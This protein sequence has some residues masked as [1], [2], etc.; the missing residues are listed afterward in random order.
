MQKPVLS[1]IVPA[2]NEE[3]NIKSVIL[4]LAKLRNRYPLEIIVVDD[5]SRDKTSQIAEK[6]GADKIVRHQRNK[7]KGAGFRTGVKNSVGEY[8]VQIDAD[9]QL[10]ASDIPILIDRI[11]SGADLVLGERFNYKSLNSSQFTSKMKMAGNILVSSITTIATRKKIFDVM[12][13]LK[14]IRKKKV[15]K[16]LPKSND[17]AYEAEMVVLAAKKGLNIA[18][19]PI[20]CRERNSGSSNLS[21]FKHG[22]SVVMTIVKTAL[23]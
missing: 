3:K 6:F 11:E 18:T 12:T 22:L 15:N 2:Y 21:S 7:G 5:A 23:Q 16:I 10:M 4:D 19:V 8:I 13:G 20:K 1:I 17:F 9:G 14:A